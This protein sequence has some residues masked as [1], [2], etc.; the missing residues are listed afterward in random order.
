LW[1]E[2]DRRFE[3]GSVDVFNARPVGRIARS[4]FIEE[5]NLSKKQWRSRTVPIDDGM[6]VCACAHNVT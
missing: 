6:T 2:K 1:V 3:E 5:S 4:G